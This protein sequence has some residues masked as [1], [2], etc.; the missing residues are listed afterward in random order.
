L[1]R[2]EK[3]RRALKYFKRKPKIVE[4]NW[5]IDSI[6]KGEVMKPEPYELDVSAIK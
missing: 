3:I 2:S 1:E 4:L 5:L 6:M